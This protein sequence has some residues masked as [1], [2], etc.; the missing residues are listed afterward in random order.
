MNTQEQNALKLFIQENKS[1]NEIYKKFA[2][3]YQ[4][5]NNLS[6]IPPSINYD[7][8][9]QNK[10]IRDEEDRLKEQQINMRIQQYLKMK[11]NNLID[12]PVLQKTN[13]KS[14]KLASRI[15]N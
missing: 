4:P 5:S 6:Y 3:L 9:K 12:Y 15:S 8:L 10:L 2:S 1:P 14:S 13:Y 11:P 7:K